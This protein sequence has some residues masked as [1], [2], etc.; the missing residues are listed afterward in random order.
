MGEIRPAGGGD[1]GEPAH[2]VIDLGAPVIDTQDSAAADAA[3]AGA[4]VGQLSWRWIEAQ[5]RRLLGSF[6]GGGPLDLLLADSEGR[7]AI[8][9]AAWLGRPLAALGDPGERGTYLVSH[10][11]LRL[12]AGDAG[13]AWTVI[14]REPQAQALAGARAVRRNVFASVLAFGLAAALLA[15]LATQALMTRLTRLA[16]QADALRQGLRTDLLAPPGRDEVSRI[17]ATLA[18]TVAQLQTEKQALQALNAALDAR[19]AERTARIEHMAQEN[20]HAAVV[21]ERLRMAR[22]LHD[23]LAHSL[24]ALLTQIR[25]VRKL[26]VQWS[27][28]QRDAELGRAEEAAADGLRQARAAITQMRHNDV[29]DTGLGPA[30]QD[31]L[32]RF[33]RRS[34]IAC[35]DRF[36]PRAASLADERAETVF[37]IVEE[38]LNNVERHSQA[39]RIAVTLDWLGSTDAADTRQAPARLRLRIEDDGVGFEPGH[40]RAGHYGLRGMREQAALLSATLEIDSA[41][42][43]GTRVTLTLDA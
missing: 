13:A 32:A 10:A 12:S 6:D 36:D 23:T 26:G 11:S 30:L 42:G 35:D 8:G 17:G 18:A 43:Q 22:E 31:L 20:Q 15:V 29:A 33:S 28:E 14:V 9:P 41:P 2:R 24:V 25:L 3:P 4:V 40:A 37:R 38:V 5:A 34:G 16:D 21:R 1:G 39:R 19:V 27:A 7:L